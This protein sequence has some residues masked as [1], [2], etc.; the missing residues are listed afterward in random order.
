MDILKTLFSISKDDSKTDTTANSP[1]PDPNDFWIFTDPDARDVHARQGRLNE[2]AHD[3][4]YEVMRAGSWEPEELEYKY[5]IRR[6]LQEGIISD[7]GTY[8]FTSPFPTVYRAIRD[9]SLTISGREFRFR[10]GNDIVFQC[11]MVR[12]ANPDLTSMVLV[13]Y[14][15]PTDKSVLCSQMG[16]AMKGMPSKKGA[17]L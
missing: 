9:G 1:D 13:G 10:T 16:S 5:E 7:K 11:R 17:R 12:D 4:Q 3:I 15:Q 2:L 8:W 6:L 14:L